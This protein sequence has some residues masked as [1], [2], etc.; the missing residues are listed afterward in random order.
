MKIRDFY[1]KHKKKTIIIS[2]S[3]VTVLVI[4][5]GTAIYCLRKTGS[6]DGPAVQMAIPG[7]NPGTD[8]VSASGL[9][10]VGMSEETLA[11]ENQEI[12]LLIEEV[13]VSSGEQVSEGD[14]I[15]KLSGD[16]VE[17]AQELLETAARQ[18]LLDYRAGLIAYEQSLITA[19]SERDLAILSGEQADQVY[20]ETAA[21]LKSSVD[22]AEKALAEAKEKIAQYQKA[23]Q[24]NTY[25]EYYKVGEY[26]DIYDENLKLL[27][28]RMEEWGIGWDQVLSG[29]S[30]GSGI[31]VG[32]GTSG[33]SG[34]ESGGLEAG[35]NGTESGSRAAV[36]SGQEP[37]LVSVSSVSGGDASGIS[38]SA[39]EDK[40]YLTVLKSLYSV[41]EQNLKEYEQARSDY[42]DAA[43]NAGF[44][45]QT[46]QLSLST[47]EKNV[48]EAREKYETQLLE[49]KL[50]L[51]TSLAG[52]ERAQNDYETAVEKAE[53]DLE[54]I[55]GALEDAREDVEGFEN[56]IKDGYYCAGGSGTILR[57][58]ARSEQYLT[59]GESLFLYS[60]TEEMTVS[61]SVDQSDIA[62]ISIGDTAWVDAGEYGS[63]QGVVTAI[64][65][66]SSSDSRTSVVYSVTVTLSGDTGDLAAN[67][68]VTVM[69]GLGGSDDE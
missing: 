35:G 51:E 20:E 24:S 14:P 36:L 28:T 13:C 66:V 64:N 38:P 48:T 2:V 26:K 56:S 10:G 53:A 19:E 39:N 9:T 25:Y 27:T 34:T 4:A 46:L 11:V 1:I 31:T 68:N 47:L 7:M 22:K 57:V 62:R 30:A 6:G 44:E 58:M 54:K 40:G 60:N 65:P 55:K 50:T 49:A 21:S 37:A 3:M 63:F 67:Q 16:S 17:E 69:I 52:A 5:G 15:L 23:A 43:A 45:L 42:E 18:A 41:L 29:Q 12:K 8:S 61:L 59:G 33:G 32:S